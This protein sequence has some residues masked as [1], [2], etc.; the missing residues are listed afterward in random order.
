MNLNNYFDKIYVLN[1][2]KRKDRLIDIESRLKRFGIN[3]E[4]FGATDGSTMKA[5]WEK[6]NNPY[7]TNPNYL[8][9]AVSHLSIYRDAIE[10]RYQKILIIEDDV[11]INNNI[12]VLFGKIDIPNWEDLLYLGYIPLSDDQTMWNY[13]IV[14]V[15]PSMQNGLFIPQCFSPKNL[16]G[17]FSYGITNTL[18][19]E[20]LELYQNSFPMEIDRYFVNNIQSRGKSIA[21][22]PQLFC[23]QDIYSDNMS[24]MQYDMKI[25]SI[26][27][28]FAYIESYE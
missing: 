26:D 7:F 13:N 22:S 10:R 9:C 4:V 18:M 11:L 19:S 16:W 8:A 27:T 1:L 5:I 28:R 3:Y 12:N 21:I 6:F 17:L 15:I 23:C 2:H 24:S 20:I 14:N 25:R